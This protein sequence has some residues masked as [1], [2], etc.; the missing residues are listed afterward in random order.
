MALRDL[1]RAQGRPAHLETAWVRPDRPALSALLCAAGVAGSLLAVDA[2]RAGL[3]I[4]LVAF[5][6]LAGDASGLAPVARL[7]LPR[8]ATQTVVSEPP[9]A[10]PT[11]RVR[12]IVTAGIDAGRTGV[13]AR[14]ARLE[15]RARRA[16]GGHLPSPVAV[17]CA[18]LALL[19]ALAAARVAGASGAWLGIAALPPT[20]ALVLGAA[21]YLDLATSAPSPGANAHASAAAAAIAVTTA[22]DRLPPRHLAVELV[23][24]GASEGGQLGFAAYVR[25]RRRA[26]RPQELAVL[27]F[28]PSGA[29]R[30]RV[31]LTEGL[32]LPARLHPGLLALARAIPGAAPVRR[33][34][35]GALV[36]RRAGWPAVGVSA[37]DDDDRPGPARTADDS[38][39]RLDRSSIEAVVAY[40]LEVVR[41]LDRQL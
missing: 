9:R 10:A 33:Q 40:A 34:S 25:R 29:G 14:L 5:V 2:P 17:L 20:V 7:L 16:L 6:A 27:A 28:G 36:A 23:L 1:L 15:S 31:H 18:S 37:L 13:A 22:L 24:A 3:A 32:L 12:L 4:L 19:T 26:A 38:P 35:T 21:A 30:P 11:A 39:D 41:A 8:R